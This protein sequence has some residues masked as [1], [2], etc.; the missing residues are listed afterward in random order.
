[1]TTATLTE[2]LQQALP[3]PY[4]LVHRSPGRIRL[5]VPGLINNPGGQQRLQSQ[6]AVLPWVQSLR[7]NGW[8][9]SVVIHYD[10]RQKGS[11]AT[12]VATV[13]Q[14]MER[15]SYEKSWTRLVDVTQE[16]LPRLY[17]SPLTLP[18]LATGLALASNQVTSKLLET[19]AR[20]TLLAAALPVA[21]RAYVSVATQRKINIDCLD[22]MAL[23][24]SGI[25]GKLVTPALV[26]TLHELGDLIREK[27]ARATEQTT[28]NLMDTIG[29]EAWVQREGE[30]IRV[31]SDQVQLGETVVVYPGERIPVD[32][33]VLSG[34]A[35]VDQQQLTGESM[36]IVATPGTYVYAATL[37]RSGQL[38]L[39]CERVGN[40]TR[41][42]ASIELLAKAPVN[43]TRMANYAAQLADKLI[44]PSLVLAAVVYGTTQDPTRAASILTL[45]FVTGVRVSMPTAFL[46][47]LNHTTRHGVLVRSGRT[48]E[49][50][51]A[52]DTVVFDKTGTLTQGRIVVDG[53]TCLDDRHTET[54]ILQWAASA[55]QR[56]TH[57]VA[58]AIAAY[59][60]A[61][62]I[63]IRPR[64]HWHY[65]VGSGMEAEIEGQTIWV[66]SEAFLRSKGLVSPG[67]TLPSGRGGQS[68]VYV[69][70][71]EE[72]LGFISYTDPLRPESAALVNTFQHHYQ[73]EVHVLTG[74]SVKRAQEVAQRLGIPAAQVHAEAFPE[75][76]ARIVRDLRRSG[77]VVAFVGDGL[78]DSV[79]LAYADVSISFADGS[80]IARETADVV[81]MNNDL[82][83]ILEAIAI[84]KE[85]QALIEQN[86]LLVVAPNVVGL[87]LAATVGLNPLWATLIHNGTAI[88]AGL[89]SLRPLALHPF[90]TPYAITD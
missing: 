52:I 12:S 4:Q 42:A 14:G 87:G 61:Q 70:N 77:R 40:Q 20:L 9:G 3:F 5:K 65:Q 1:M 37:L 84:A 10:K 8:A 28:A 36:P 29:R 60:Q 90:E 44:V 35:T 51:A 53:V 13:T 2:A 31:P 85:T 71:P 48:L 34:E 6:L 58:E 74:D 82:T 62:G 27:T 54:Q 16:V 22:L 47:A 81:L 11:Q 55:E 38:R 76:K 78:N 64:Q 26:I 75:D 59:A 63:E 43:D 19:L 7:I 89:N 57:P 50:L 24:L 68:V 88:L 73:L 72:V 15:A 23:G 45:D 46:G 32:G 79:A 86:T 67:E 41:A 39:R 30:M 69:A 80:D 33:E 49:M 56:I 66:G 17:R 83:S 21:Q 18:L 25:Q